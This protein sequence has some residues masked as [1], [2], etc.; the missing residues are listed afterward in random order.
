MVD[1][2][3]LAMGIVAL[4]LVV[5][6]PLGILTVFDLLAGRWD[7]TIRNWRTNRRVA[8]EHRRNLKAMRQQTGLPIEQLAADLRR[9]RAAI[10]SDE[11]RSAAHQIGNRLAYDRILIQACAMLG[12]EHELDEET[13]GLERDIER[14][15]VEADLERAGVVIS[16][17]RYG[18]AA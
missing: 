9:L 2:A 1:A 12:I 10:A 18:Q 15:R 16:T 3:Q 4:S 8:A 14:L 6:A 11:H 5:L 7:G 13:S 17:R